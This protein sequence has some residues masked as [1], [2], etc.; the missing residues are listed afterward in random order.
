[1]ERDH[2]FLFAFKIVSKVKKRKNLFTSPIFGTANVVIYRKRKP[3]VH[4]LKMTTVLMMMRS[5]KMLA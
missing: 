2:Y 5:L 1:M 3:K 4:C